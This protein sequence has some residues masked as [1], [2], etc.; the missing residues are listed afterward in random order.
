MSLTRDTDVTAKIGEFDV[1]NSREEKLLG[2]KIDSKLFFENDVSFLYKK[3]SQK[4]HAV[5]RVVNFMDLAKRKS[6]MKVF[7][8]SQF[9]YCILIWMFHSRQLNNRINKIQE[10]ALRLP[11]KDNKLTFDDLLKLDNSVTIHQR[12]IQILVTEIFKVKNSLAP[13]IMTEVFEIKEP[14]YNFRSE[15]SHIKRENVKSTHCNIQSV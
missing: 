4:L 1:K 14:H 3:A 5:A 7:I 6:L 2:I 8:T 15:A 11:H 12:N 13:E 10:T 9:N